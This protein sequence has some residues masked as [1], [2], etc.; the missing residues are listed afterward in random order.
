MTLTQINRLSVIIA[1][2]YELSVFPNENKN[3]TKVLPCQTQIT[4][5][6]LKVD[7]SAV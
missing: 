5:L 4:I 2:E 1:A 6:R 3:K 7:K